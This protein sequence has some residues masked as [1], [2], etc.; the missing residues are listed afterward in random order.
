MGVIDFYKLN[1]N[2]EEFRETIKNYNKL[3]SLEEHLL[4]GGLGSIIAETIVDG[5]LSTQLKRIGLKEYIYAYG[6]RE[7]IQKKCGIDVDSVIQK[8]SNY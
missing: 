8:I 1:S 5:G 4:A 7:N 2:G 6:G 3:V